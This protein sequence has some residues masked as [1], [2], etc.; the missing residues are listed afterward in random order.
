MRP[1]LKSRAVRESHVCGENLGLREAID[2]RKVGIHNTSRGRDIVI[3]SNC[4]QEGWKNK[5]RSFKS[6]NS[7]SI[8]WYGFIEYTH[9]HTHRIPKG[10]VALSNQILFLLHYRSVLPEP[11]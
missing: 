8:C 1:K 5:D 9:T 2:P 10:P 7:K 11:F 4:L 3:S 6:S